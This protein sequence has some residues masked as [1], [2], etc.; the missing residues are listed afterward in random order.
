MQSAFQ[1]GGPVPSAESVVALAR[2]LKLSENELLDL[3]R[4][5]TGEDAVA[6]QNDLG[7]GKLI[8]EW[9]PYALEVHPAGPAVQG[10]TLAHGL[11]LPGYVRRNHDQLLTNAVNDAMQGRSR[12]MVL[13]GSSSAGKTRACWEAVQ[14]LADQGWLLWHPFDP[15][16]VEAALQDLARVTPRTVIWLNEAQHYLGDPSAG[17]R[18]AAGLHALL[19]DHQ[20]GPV[21]VLG[22]LWPEYAQTYTTVPQPG[23]SDPHS[24]VRELLAGCMVTVP[25]TF[26][27]E[28]LRTATTLAEAG[29]ALL[30]DALIRARTTGRVAQDLAGAPELLRRYEQAVPPT[31]ALLE[32]AMDA[33]RLGVGLHLPQAFLTDAATDYLSD[34]ELDELTEDWAEAAYADLA[35]PVH[36]KQAPLRRT[37]ARP[38]R[39]PPGRSTQLATEISPAGRGPVFR[40]ADYLE[41]HGRTARRRLCPPASFW[42]A[43]YTHLTSPNELRNVAQE[44]EQM[45]RLQWSHD[46]YDAAAEAGSAEALS[47]LAQLRMRA[48]DGEGAEELL[49]RAV[50]AGHTSALLALA[51]LRMTAGDAEGAEGLLRRAVNVGYPPALVDLARLRQEAGDPEEATELLQRAV[52]A[53][54]SYALLG[55]VRLLERAGDREGAEEAAWRAVEAGHTVTLGDVPWLMDGVCEAGFQNRLGHAVDAQSTFVLDELARLRMRAGDGEGAEELLQRAVDAGHTSALLA[56]ARLRMTAGDAEGA[57]ELLRRAADAGHTSALDRLVAVRMRVGDTDGA[58]ELLQRA[59]DAGQT[60]V[61]LDLAQLRMEAGDREGAEGLLRRAVDAGHVIALDTLARLR[62]DAGDTDEAEA[63]AW[64]AADAGN[65]FV[66]VKLARMRQ[67]AGNQR[68]AE[69]LLR[70]AADAGYTDPSPMTEEWVSTAPEWRYGLDP[71][72]TPTPPWR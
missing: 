58:E 6:P 17:E 16:R 15:T 49:Q 63:I 44:A 35:Q 70:Q 12:M 23:R 31:R 36:G 1:D 43:A 62:E 20:R 25:D 51:R 64:A 68:G 45:Q 41:Q 60:A 53:D 38:A 13:V 26:D 5:A 72:G 30:A 37:G 22:T 48:G 55:L 2:T 47:H 34:D 56:L 61:L 69:R 11:V 3:R 42:H 24:R 67:Q 46:L 33:R 27:E 28:A 9:N 66:L 52:D 8:T 10:T 71:D 7:P 19:A 65:R 54:L 57:E 59:A 29:D 50:D 40:L 21:L 32:A 39:R 14:L 18:V 4:T